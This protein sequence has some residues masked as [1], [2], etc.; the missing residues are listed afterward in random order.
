MNTGDR[1]L[2]PHLQVYRFQWTMAFSILHRATGVALAVG[3]L[4]LVCW[5]VALADGPEA[6]AAVQDF[7][8]TWYGRLLLFGWTWSLIYHLLAGL[9]HLVWDT[10]VGLGLPAAQASGY[11]AAVGSVVLTI[12]VWAAAYQALGRL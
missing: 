2:S 1:P 10:G 6:F 12:L 3:A 7:L 11:L 9:R 4:M 5:L 8:V